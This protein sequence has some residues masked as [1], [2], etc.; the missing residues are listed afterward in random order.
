LGWKMIPAN[1]FVVIAGIRLGIE[2]SL[3]RYAPGDGKA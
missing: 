3:Q 1:D 2:D